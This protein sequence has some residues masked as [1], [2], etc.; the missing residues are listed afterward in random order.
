MAR[1]GKYPARLLHRRVQASIGMG[2]ICALRSAWGP[3]LH[4]QARIDVDPPIRL[5]HVESRPHR[6]RP[7]CRHGRPFPHDRAGAAGDRGTAATAARDLP[8][9]HPPRARRQTQLQTWHCP[10]LCGA[11]LP[12]VPAT[13]NSGLFWPRRSLVRLPGTI[14][15]EFLRP[16]APGF[17]RTGFLAHLQDT[18]EEA[19][20]R[21]LQESRTRIQKSGIDNQ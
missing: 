10:S 5:V 18:I 8:G 16:I 15:V 9:R 6:G 19:S 12:C 17:D 14:V 3:D 1:H 13:L 11:G 20:A 7:Q 21:L 4:P 2:N